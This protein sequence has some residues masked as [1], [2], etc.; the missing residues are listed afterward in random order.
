MSNEYKCCSYCGAF[1]KDCIHKFFFAHWTEENKF[2]CTKESCMFKYL[3]ESHSKINS[4][5]NRRS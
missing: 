3:L 2:C 5:L 4:I 1:L